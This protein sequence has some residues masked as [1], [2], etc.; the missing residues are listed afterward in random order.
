MKQA[1]LKKI[2]E[3]HKEWIDSGYSKGTRADLSYADLSR[4]DLSY[5]NLSYA[6]LSRAKGI[7]ADE[8]HS[9]FWIIP[10]EG[11]FTG[12]KKLKDNVVAKIEIPAKAKRTCNLMGR[13][14]RAEYAKTIA[15]Y[16]E[17]K[18]FK[19][20]GIGSHDGKTKY[21]VGKITKPDKY[22][23]SPLVECSNGIHFFITRQEA[24]SYTC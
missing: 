10:E 3:D 7:E 13:K 2:L 4:A 19:G 17:G 9:V 1:D 23:G 12:W 6:K 11:S 8:M 5:A 22:D 14:C 15:L 21:N 16:Q 18:P 20:V 24:E